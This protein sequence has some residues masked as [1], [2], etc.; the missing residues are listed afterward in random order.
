MSSEIRVNKI[1]NRAGLGTVEYTPTGIIV[2]GIVTA[3]EFD[4]NFDTTPGIVVTGIATAAAIDLNGDLDVDG[5][6]NLDN[7]SVA[8]ITTIS[9]VLHASNTPASI[10]VAQDIQHLSDTDTKI[11]FPAADTVALETGGTQGVRLTSAQ[12]LLVGN[13]T[14]SRSVGFSEHVIQT[15]GS[16]AGANG[17]SIYATNSSAHA[18]HF[19]FGKS[20]NNS[21]V[22]DNDYLGHILWAAHDGTDVDNFAARITGRIDGT[23]GSNVTPG[24]LEFYTVSAGSNSLGG[25][26]RLVIN[27]SGHIVP[28]VDSSYDLGLTGTRFRNVYADTLYGDGSN[29]TGITQTT[30]N[31]NANNRL[32]TGSGT[33]NTLEGEANLTFDGDSL[34]LLS[35]TDGRRVSFAGGGTSHYMKFDNTLNGIILNGYGGIAFETNGTNERLRIDSGGRMGLGTNSPSSYN[36]KAYNFVIASSSHA[37]M[38]IAG[39]TTSDSSIYFADGTSGAAQYAGWIQYEHDNNALTFGVN[40]SERFRIQSDGK[41]GIGRNDPV[42][43]V[44]IAR[45]QDEENILLVRGADNTTEYGALGI[46]SGNYVI[47]GGGAGSTN[48]GIMFRTAASGNETNRLLITS[49]GHVEPATDDTYD[50]GSLTKRWANIYTADLNLSNEGKANDVDGTWGQYTIQEGQDDLYLINKRNGKKYKF[51]LQEV[52]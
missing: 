30:I 37:G 32:I 29:L 4:G 17:I 19:T 27:S 38:T 15:E 34:L 11:S 6:T 20:R 41:I 14:S 1:N 3:Y 28:G 40:T 8:G 49:S 16:G 10:R 2:S 23:V 31:N 48:T 46:H 21:T 50:F 43:F 22:A 35:S 18:G 42:N 39:G 33:A 24:S 7:V 51:L 5:H 26:P 9:G 13:H 45:G 47:T 44:D 36:N 52:S 12:K 25:T